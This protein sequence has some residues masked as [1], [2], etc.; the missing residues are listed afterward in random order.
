MQ[1]GAFRGASVVLVPNPA[2]P[3]DAILASGVAVFD[4]V[5]ALDGSRGPKYERL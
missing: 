5:N 3:R 2:W 4:A 1:A